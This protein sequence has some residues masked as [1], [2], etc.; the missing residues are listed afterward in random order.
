M[1]VTPAD[2]S[3][4]PASHALLGSMML[5]SG[6]VLLALRGL[7]SVRLLTAFPSFWH[8]HNAIWWGIGFAISGFG[9]WLLAQQPLEEG[10]D[11]WRPARAGQ[12]F[13]TLLLYTRDGCHLCDEARETLE[14]HRPWLPEVTEL[15]I[16][17]DPRL[18]ERY[19]DCVPVVAVDGKVRFRGRVS[20]VLLRRLIDATPPSTM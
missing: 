17:H 8:D 9:A 13:K 20:P 12:R 18:I 7:Q 16:D 14:Q 2:S 19:G 1:R 6:I 11:R 4:P 3:T 10:R 5:L 15:D